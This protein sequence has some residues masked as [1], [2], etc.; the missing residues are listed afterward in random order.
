VAAQYCP[1]A[2]RATPAD[3]RADVNDLP[4]TSGLAMAET[5]ADTT[6]RCISGTP[7]CTARFGMS[8]YGCC[9]FAQISLKGPLRTAAETNNR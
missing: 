4:C 8:P 7:A 2:S 9:G 6:A 5:A 1:P 3:G